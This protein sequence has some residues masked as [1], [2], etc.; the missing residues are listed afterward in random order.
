MLGRLR[1]GKLHVRRRYADYQM[2]S[3]VRIDAQAI[4]RLVGTTA[5]SAGAQYYRNGKVRSFDVG[6][7]MITGSVKGTDPQPYSLRIGILPTGKIGDGYCSCPVG[8]DCKHCA[9]VLY[10]V[11]DDLERTT[12][13]T[14]EDLQ[15]L[16]STTIN[17]AR[18]RS[19]N[20]H[21]ETRVQAKG[22]T[23]EQRATSYV[24]SGAVLSWLEQV[25][26]SL[27]T[28]SEEYPSSILNRLVYLF[29]VVK[30]GQRPPILTLTTFVS[31]ILKSG[32]LSESTRPYTPSAALGINPAKYLRPSDRKILARLAN[33]RLSMPF[34][35]VSASLIELLPEIVA[36]GRA[37][38]ENLSGPP[39]RFGEPIEG[40]F[41]WELNEF[42]SLRP[43]I[44]LKT[45]SVSED[46]EAFQGEPPFYLS[47]SQRTIGM[48]TSHVPAS[49]S[50]L[51][52]RAP[53]LPLEARETIA[54]QFSTHFP[55][56]PELTPPP[57]PVITS[58]KVTPRAR[59]TLEG[60]VVET[61]GRSGGP[62]GRFSGLL[63]GDLATAHLQFCY[64]TLII[65]PHR[66]ER[67]FRSKQGSE[68][69][70]FNRDF[71]FERSA[72]ESLEDHGFVALNQLIG[73]QGIPSVSKYLP[74]DATREGWLQ[75]LTETIPQLEA[76][77]WEI[78]LRKDFP[79]Q[80]PQPAGDFD[81]SLDSGTGID[82]LDLRV[83]I[84]VEGEKVDITGLISEFLRHLPDLELEQVGDAELES[85]T[86]VLDL[87]NGRSVSIGEQ[88]LL[89]LLRS[90]KGALTSNEGDT[91]GSLVGGAARLAALNELEE[92][93]PDLGAQI[94][95]AELFR[96]M[97]AR[98]HDLG[99]RIP[100]TTVPTTFTA[101]LRPYQLEG[102]AW[103]QFLTGLGFGAVLADDM[104]LG[105]TVQ[106]LAHVAVD[107]SASPGLPPVLI[108]APTSVIPN[109]E[110]EIERFA[111]TLS[112]QTLQGN[113]KDLRVVQ[114]PPPDIVLTS[115]ALLHRDI[116]QLKEITWHD[117]ILDEAQNLK[118]A[119]S[120]TSRAIVQLRRRATVLLTGTP[121]E[122]HIGELWSLMR[123]VE[124]TLLGDQRS[125]NARYRHPI[126]RN[127]DLDRLEAL[128]ARIRPFLLR[129]T[130]DQV[131]KELPPKTEIYHRIEFDDAQRDLYDGIR[132]A[133]MSKVRKAIDDRGFAM[134]RIVILDAL[135]KLRQV[136]CDPRL[137]KSH[138]G[139]TTVGSAKL[140]RLMELLPEFME[141]G[142]RVLLFSQ[143]TSMLDLIQAEVERAQI[144][145]VR[146]DGSTKDRSTPVQ[147]FQDGEVPLFLI[148]LKAGGTGLNLTAADSIVIYDP[149]WNPA[150]EAQAIDRAHRIGQDKPVFVHRLVA[151]GTVEEK[152][153]ELKA[154]KSELAAGIYDSEGDLS[155]GL[156]VEDIDHLLD[157]L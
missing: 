153:T 134:S 138:D 16:E 38:L 60:T 1:R 36:T 83:G 156:S 88:R 15:P 65:E 103:L 102:V 90:L 99:G 97:A 66:S 116:A 5:A 12:F 56:L 24:P 62:F 130:K 59:L 104:G 68:V 140:I 53:E 129:R 157:A 152:M 8:M 23:S 119:A 84:E 128:K 147:R 100:S 34:A 139:S 11:L 48:I 108:V 107:R 155:A 50:S 61:G 145:F 142:S 144:P 40:V 120:L 41:S 42:A 45:D 87:G 150:V 93:A 132:L 73:F 79:V 71:V 113:H 122:N 137:V 105:K 89:R 112:F 118:N 117:I 141:E 44:S 25:D 95:G 64:G 92:L 115:Y 74:H 17:A 143:F 26:R 57:A 46:L 39:L 124:P 91:S 67:T 96:T 32:G 33:E 148:S 106:A 54:R 2:D 133:M 55:Q 114:D 20:L 22:P 37:F 109:W 126:E 78:V 6:D 28:A 4:T 72:R 123:H 77:G 58:I 111:P 94:R 125:F 19:S 49:V 131:V 110:N 86:I 29:K 76:E 121:M 30:Q 136:C 21:S 151:G 63:L 75:V 14:R 146:L 43:A 31:R 13:A 35:M 51:L 80:P 98:L 7:K 85:T 27:E 101:T 52:L 135:L 149:W 18:Q 9:A 3:H 82:W 10:A 47:P 154:R 69:V 81:L 70:T 127:R